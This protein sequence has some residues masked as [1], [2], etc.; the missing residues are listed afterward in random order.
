MC[1]I[2]TLFIFLTTVLCVLFSINLQFQKQSRPQS[3]TITVARVWC[4]IPH[5]AMAGQQFV[6]WNNIES[7]HTLLSVVRLLV[8]YSKFRNRLIA[9]RCYAYFIWPLSVMIALKISVFWAKAELERIQFASTFMCQFMWW[10]KFQYKH[11]TLLISCQF[12]RIVSLAVSG[13]FHVHFPTEELP[14]ICLFA[15]I[16][17]HDEFSK[18]YRWFFIYLTAQTSEPYVLAANFYKLIA[19]FCISKLQFCCSCFPVF[20]KNHI[21]STCNVK[22]KQ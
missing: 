11:V 1:S 8:Q 10:L 2:Q 12:N 18:K 22:C 20:W 15:V 4:Y 7:E 6:F 13:C 3:K 14:L 16:E 21:Y 19:D 17:E 5:N 9:L